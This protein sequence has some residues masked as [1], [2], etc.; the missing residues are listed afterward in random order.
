MSL[1]EIR[2]R[3]F[4]ELEQRKRG[5]NGRRP[6][7]GTHKQTRVEWH[8]GPRGEA[9]RRPPSPSCYGELSVSPG[10]PL[11]SSVPAR[12]GLKGEAQYMLTS[13]RSRR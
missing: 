12:M 4:A 9:V 11:L 3:H 2:C 1:Q 6:V 10:G 13:I 7:S 5:P 8:L